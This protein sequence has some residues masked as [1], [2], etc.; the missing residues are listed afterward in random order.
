VKRARQRLTVVAAVLFGVD[1][2]GLVPIALHRAWLAWLAG[3][4][5]MNALAWIWVL[6][7]WGR[8]R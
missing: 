5:T 3:V 2:G 4:L 1:I 6:R 7:R 8:V